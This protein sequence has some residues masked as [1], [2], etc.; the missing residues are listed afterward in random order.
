M[1]SIRNA[2]DELCNFVMAITKKDIGF[3]AMPALHSSTEASRPKR[4]ATRRPTLQP[5]RHAR[6]TFLVSAGLA[7]AFPGLAGATVAFPTAK[8]PTDLSLWYERPAGPW[9]E[10]LPV[11]N[12]RLGAMVFGRVAQE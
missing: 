11:G 6:R 10:A 3:K 8:D 2:T 9:V 12:G 7:T 4:A 5:S 1:R